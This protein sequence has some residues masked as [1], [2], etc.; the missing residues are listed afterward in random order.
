MGNEPTSYPG[1]QT[2]F[3]PW[4]HCCPVKS[5]RKRRKS[6]LGTRLGNEHHFLK[7]S[8]MCIHRELEDR[9]IGLHTMTGIFI[10]INQSNKL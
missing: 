5:K 6:T 8:L 1:H 4:L 10:T 9:V 3:P 7:N 2:A